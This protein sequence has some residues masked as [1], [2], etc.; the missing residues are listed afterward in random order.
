MARTL[1]I[2]LPDDLEQQLV[3]QAEQLNLPVET[4]VLRSL[5]QTLTL[6]LPDVQ[7]TV[8]AYVAIAET[9]TRIREARLAGHDS[10]EISC[11]PITFHLAQS[12]K[13]GGTIHDFE[14]VGQENTTHL[15]IHLGPQ[16][17]PNDRDDSDL[18]D[19]S[20]V[21]EELQSLLQNLGSADPTARIEAVVALGALYSD[22][23]R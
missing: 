1:V 22:P 11:E 16:P 23:R 3:S 10:T 13:D 6:P 20:D 18:W 8:G 5:A 2:E 15:L 4:V 12:L 7:Q 9:L 19:R 14:V 21:P 17:V